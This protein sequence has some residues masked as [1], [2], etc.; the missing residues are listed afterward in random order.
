MKENISEDNN[1]AGDW[2]TLYLSLENK[3]CRCKLANTAYI[4]RLSGT[5]QKLLE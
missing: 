4:R 1:L 3:I 5:K 2:N